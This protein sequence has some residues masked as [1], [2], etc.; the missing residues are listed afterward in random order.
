MESLRF[1]L[2]CF[3]RQRIRSPLT[4]HQRHRG[5]HA[6]CWLAR[7]DWPALEIRF[8]KCKRGPHGPLVNDS[9]LI[10]IL[11]F[12]FFLSFFPSLPFPSFQKS[13]GSASV[14]LRWPALCYRAGINVWVF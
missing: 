12:P 5:T 14:D 3:G 7:A 2:G 13:S 4:T 11:S 9:C 8:L 6:C 10:V 1:D